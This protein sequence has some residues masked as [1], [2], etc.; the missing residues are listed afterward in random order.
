MIVT[1]MRTKK[2]R[3]QVIKKLTEKSGN[4]RKEK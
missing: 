2:C 4:I 1:A 3:G